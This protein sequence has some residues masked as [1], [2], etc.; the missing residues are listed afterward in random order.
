MRIDALENKVA[1]LEQ[2][3]LALQLERDSSGAGGVPSMPTFWG[4]DD[5][6]AD[7]AKDKPILSDGDLQSVWA[8]IEPLLNVTSPEAALSSSIQ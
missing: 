2:E 5:A 6:F 7:L 1:T 4:Y 3:N 8:E